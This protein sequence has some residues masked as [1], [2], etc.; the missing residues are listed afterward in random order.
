MLLEN[1]KRGTKRVCP[2]CNTRFYDLLRES[3]PCPSCGVQFVAAVEAVAPPANQAP[4][5]GW[6]SKPYKRPEP[7]RQPDLEVTSEAAGDDGA[8]DST[9]EEAPGQSPILI[10]YSRMNLTTRTISPIWSSTRTTRTGSTNRSDCTRP[11]GFAYF[12]PSRKGGN[13]VCN[14]RA[15]AIVLAMCASLPGSGKFLARRR[16]EIST[17]ASAY[18][19]EMLETSYR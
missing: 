6:R 13:Q 12:Q 3:I 15:M 1:A 14:I 18:R 10:Q 17:D 11:A 16:Y 7:V 4:K 2:E 5:A 19:L 8:I 9:N